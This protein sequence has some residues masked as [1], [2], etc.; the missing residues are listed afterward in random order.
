MKGLVFTEFLEMVEGKF[1]YNTVDKIIEN[2]QL[3][4][5][6]AYTSIGTYSHSEMVSLVVNLSKETEIPVPDLLKVFG[7]YL[8]KVLSKKYSHFFEGVNGTFDFLGN[9]DRYIHV[10]VKKI[11]PDAELPKFEISKLSENKIEMVYGSDRKMADL[12]EGL[13]I[14]AFNY[15]NEKAIITQQPVEE[16]GKQVKFIIEKV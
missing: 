7:E 14:G 8:L 10:E 13:I 5:G 4:S 11:Y 6:G 12:A 16:S 3:P 1:G 15:F 2:S 9:V